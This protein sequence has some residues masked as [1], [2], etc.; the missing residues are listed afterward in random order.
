MTKTTTTP[1]QTNDLRFTT[2]KT[3]GKEHII[4]KI[5][6]NDACKNGHQDFSITGTIYQADKPTTDKYML[7]GGCIHEEIEKHFP[8]FVPFIRLHLCDYQGIPMHASANGYYFLKNGFN[9]TPIESPEFVTKY[10]NYYR[11]TPEQFAEL[12]QSHSETHFALN[13]ERLGIF[14]QWQKEANAA[15]EHLEQLTGKKFLIDSK[16]TQYIR[17]SDE[18]I[19]VETDRLQNGYYSPE[20]ITEREEEKKKQEFV[21]LEADRQK[22]LQKINLEYDVKAEVLKAGGKAALDNCIFY[23]HTQTLTFNWKSYDKIPSDKLAAI[24]E[25]LNLPEG[26]KVKTKG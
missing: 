22:E 1:E 6:L 15:I 25:K 12:S 16:R 10:C 14:D 24:M 21:K 5:R 20:Q 17:P 4:V 9:K 2:S 13:L 19:K 23:N 11:I 7:A 18:K 3:V 8:E 26:V